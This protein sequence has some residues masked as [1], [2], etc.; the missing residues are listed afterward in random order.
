MKGLIVSDWLG[1]RGEFEHVVGEYYRF[2]KAEATPTGKLIN[3]ETV[4][5]GIDK[6][7]SA[8]L[9]LFTGEN[10]GKMVVKLE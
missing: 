10:I 4:V 6:A 2:G 8:F 7:V 3:K 1:C 5:V 9:G